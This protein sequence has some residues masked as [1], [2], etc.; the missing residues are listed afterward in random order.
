M[1][2]KNQVKILI[3]EVTPLIFNPGKGEREMGRWGDGEIREISIIF[4]ILVAK[5]IIL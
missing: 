5:K 1:D 4:V 2:R 3:I